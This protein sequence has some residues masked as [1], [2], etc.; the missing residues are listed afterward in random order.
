MWSHHLIRSAP[1]FISPLKTFT[2][3]FHTIQ[4]HIQFSILTHTCEREAFFRC[5]SQQSGEEFVSLQFQTTQRDMQVPYIITSWDS[6]SSGSQGRPPAG[7][8][9]WANH[10][11]CTANVCQRWS[12][13][14]SLLVNY[15][16]GNVGRG[17]GG[18]RENVLIWKSSIIFTS[19]TSHF[20]PLV[21]LFWSAWGNSF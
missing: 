21:D 10:P 13:S 11:G 18:N 12:R 5:Q 15:A 1:F 9:P 3:S 7:T 4:P 16:G 14:V 20:W 19:N 17:W 8:T 6:V 2:L